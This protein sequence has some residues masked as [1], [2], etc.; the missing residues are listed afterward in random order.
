[1]N[2]DDGESGEEVSEIDCEEV[3][4]IGKENETREDGNEKILQS[5]EVVQVSVVDHLR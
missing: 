4:E 2:D 5:E 1:M 3:E